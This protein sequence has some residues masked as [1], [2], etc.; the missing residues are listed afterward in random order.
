M[1]SNQLRFIVPDLQSGAIP[2]SLPHPQ[3]IFHSLKDS[4]F[5][6]WIWN[7]MC[8][9][10]TKTIDIWYSRWDSNSYFMAPKTIASA[11][12]ATWAL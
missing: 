7:P 1:E 4:N 6:Y 3:L 10:Y 5:H 12:W 2:P 9:H 11:N 8:Y